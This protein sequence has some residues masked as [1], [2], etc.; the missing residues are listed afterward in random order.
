MKKELNIIK[1]RL[2]E[3]EAPPAPKAPFLHANCPYRRGVPDFVAA[4][5]PRVVPLAAVPRHAVPI[6]GGVHF[7]QVDPHKPPA[8]LDDLPFVLREKDAI[9]AV[10]IVLQIV[11]SWAKGRRAV[12]YG[13]AVMFALLLLVFDALQHSNPVLGFLI[14]FVAAGPLI[15][16]SMTTML[17]EKQERE[18]CVKQAWA[19]AT[20]GLRQLFRYVVQTVVLI[21]GLLCLT[22]LG[23]YA[24]IFRCTDADPNVPRCFLS[25]LARYAH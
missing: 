20:P 9:A 14:A 13:T 19:T 2:A 6:E 8:E 7:A 24:V 16:I 5:R 3:D 18:S 22:A 17:V 15:W 10:L 23:F 11:Q 12:L 4:A 21:V 25:M 1:A